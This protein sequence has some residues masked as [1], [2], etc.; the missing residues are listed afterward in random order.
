MKDFR[1]RLRKVTVVALT[2]LMA[3]ASAW[4]GNTR[5]MAYTTTQSAATTYESIDWNN[6]LSFY[7][8]ATQQ[9]STSGI[10]LD[11]YKVSYKSGKETSTKRVGTYKYGKELPLSPT[12]K[13]SKE[14]RYRIIITAPYI[15]A[16]NA[17]VDDFEITADMLEAEKPTIQSLKKINTIRRGDRRVYRFKIGALY[18]YD[19]W[20]DIVGEV[21][22]RANQSCRFGKETKVEHKGPGDSNFK[23]ISYS[24]FE[25]DDGYEMPN[26]CNGEKGTLRIT[27]EVSATVDRG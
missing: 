15:T 16:I 5:V 14:V 2:A 4:P 25:S 8:A 9:K 20:Q 3:V 21:S 1:R 11:V 17:Y 12:K 24:A 22:F 19:R 26:M 18:D 13:G 23:Q 6:A 10:T 27:L 7:D